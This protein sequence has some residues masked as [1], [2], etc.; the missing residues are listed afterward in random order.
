MRALSG[1]LGEALHDTNDLTRGHDTRA[2]A[3]VERGGFPVI[4]G[5]DVTR[6]IAAG[7]Q[8]AV[9]QGFQR[10]TKRIV[11]LKVLH[12]ATATE[13]ATRRFQREIELIAQLRHPNIVFVFDSG[14]TADG[15]PYAVMD[16]VRG[17]PLHQH[18]RRV[19]DAVRLFVKVCDAVEH[20]HQRGIVHR[21]L[22]PSNILVDSTGEPKVLDFGLA[23]ALGTPAEQALSMTSHVMGTLAYMSP[24]QSRARHEDVD[25][26]SD[27]Y[28]LGVVLY[29]LL[30]GDFPYPIASGLS[31]TIRSI[32]EAPPTPMVQAWTYT[33]GIRAADSHDCPI[34]RDLETITL[35]ALA[36]DPARR[37]ANAG[38]MSRD[39]EAYLDGRPVQARRDSTMYLLQQHARRIARASPRG[40]LAAALGVV[41]L[42]CMGIGPWAFGAWTSASETLEKSAFALAATP[43]KRF[44]HV[45]MI[46]LDDDDEALRLAALEQL[47]DVNPRGNPQSLRALH[48][49]L[50]AKLAAYR[51]KV[52]VWN[53]EFRGPSPFDDE[54]R[55]GAAA[56]ARA[57]ARLAVAVG[58]WNVTPGQAPPIGQ[59]LV[60]LLRPGY[61]PCQ[62]S[63]NAPWDVALFVQRGTAEVLPSL[64]LVAFAQSTSPASDADFQPQLDPVS[65]AL[66]IAWFTGP[67]GNRSWLEKNA[68][69]RLSA[70]RAALTSDAELGIRPDDRVGHFVI[71]IPAD[72]A[73]QAATINYASLFDPA[74]TDGEKL[75]ERIVIIADTRASAQDRY[76]TPDGRTLY[77]VVAHATATEMLMRSELLRYA[78]PG[79]SLLITALA[80]ASGLLITRMTLERRRLRVSFLLTASAA[81][82]ALAVLGL[83][84]G[85]LYCDPLIPVSA[86]W[87]MSLVAAPTLRLQTEP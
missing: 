8:G 10:S 59:E 66:R 46:T 26:R 63:A 3:P 81:G 17:V 77:S 35:K 15:R 67:A 68:I 9:Y 14:S 11:A 21:D 76:P 60:P 38:E 47:A 25:I 22:K 29:E 32:N 44:D 2:D 4:Q 19:R 79:L 74:F 16:Y 40:T 49:R 27:V 72:A 82:V 64:S 5:Y 85:R 18:D 87:L 83:A 73:L 86:M 62:L 37:Y 7:G 39:L 28:S 70:V 69:V 61:A 75:R 84:A 42:L 55:R 24:E 48:G 36:K 6:L 31:E 80:A 51:P 52:V 53:I 20:A 12:Q 57:G 71:T 56:L 30:T 23:K 58:T 78:R 41:V 33:R 50:M 54:W 1:L 45:T 13:A 34:D 65:E 43:L